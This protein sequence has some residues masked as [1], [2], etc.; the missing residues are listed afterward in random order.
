MNE[1]KKSNRKLVYL[2]AMLLLILLI[3]GSVGFATWAVLNTQHKIGGNNINFEGTGELNVVVGKGAV[4]GVTTVE[5]NDA[6]VAE[7]DYMKQLTVTDTVDFVA[8]DKETWQGLTFNLA[9][10]TDDATSAQDLV[11][12][13]TIENKA[14]KQLQVTIT[15]ADDET[16]AA[17]YIDSRVLTVTNATAAE[18]SQ[19]T[20]TEGTDTAITVLVAAGATANVEIRINPTDNHAASITGFGYQLDF[21][22]ATVAA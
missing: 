22:N 14:D 10:K 19:L 2:T 13:F 17:T 1:K 16:Y 20:L 8:A 3:A 18:G 9:Q 11:I 21:V 5:K 6:T 7:T 12:T 15:D 4:T